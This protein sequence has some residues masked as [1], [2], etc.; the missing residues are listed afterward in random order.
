MKR[1]E[2]TANKGHPDALYDYGVRLGAGNGVPQDTDRGIYYLR[3]AHHQ[4]YSNSDMAAVAIGDIY[5]HRKQPPDYHQAK[6]WYERAPDNPMSLMSLASF[7]LDGTGGAPKDIHKS[8][9]CFRRTAELRYPPGVTNYA[10]FLIQIGRDD[11]GL[12]WY[13]KGASDET[14][15]GFHRNEISFCQCTA[16]TTYFIQEKNLRLAMF[17]AKRAVQNGSA[18]ASQLVTQL[19]AT[20]W[21]KC[22]CCHKASPSLRCGG[23]QSVAYCNAEC[24]RT[25]WKQHKKQC[26]DVPEILCKPTFQVAEGILAEWPE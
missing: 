1:L 11:E 17:W 14:W 13:V 16:A 12:K 21:A 10:G 18:P 22:G 25:H 4:D 7:Y 3:Q 9:E 24:Q 26:K 6:L 20:V 23:C 8:L 15:I 2:K 5:F 19:E